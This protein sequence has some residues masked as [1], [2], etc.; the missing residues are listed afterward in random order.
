MT[1]EEEKNKPK[2][3]SKAEADKNDDY[4]QSLDDEI[5]HVV[6]YGEGLGDEKGNE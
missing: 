4:A 3:I 1:A 6:D 2:K 5:T